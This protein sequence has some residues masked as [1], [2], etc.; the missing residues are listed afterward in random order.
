MQHVSR[1]VGPDDSPGFLL[2]RVAS[3]WQRRQGEALEP[4]GLTHVQFVLLAGVAWF[5]QGGDALTQAELAR[6]TYMDEMMT[7]QVV[8][9]LEQ[10]KLIVRTAHP[11]DQRARSLSLT[12][13]GAKLL[14]AALPI[15]ENTDV[16]FFKAAHDEQPAMLKGFRQLLAG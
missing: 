10:R 16:A 2:W 7:S 9:V 13:V 6:Q 15:V 8:R 11:R 14:K 12:K 1:F 4:L 5:T 3:E